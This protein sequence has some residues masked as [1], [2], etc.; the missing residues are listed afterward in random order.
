VRSEDFSEGARGFLNTASVGVPPRVAVEAMRDALG[1]W[2]AGRV[3][4]PEY[5]PW[6][7]RG[8]A[9][10]ARLH[11]ADAGRVAIG[12]QVS[13]FVGQVAAGLPAGARV[14]AYEDD[15]TSLLWPFLARSELDVR[16]VP[17]EAVAGAVEAG[18]DVVAFSAVQSADGRVAD[19]GAIEAAAREHGALTV[20][21]ATQASGWLPL[22]VERFDVVITA[23][24]K[25]L[26]CPRGTAFMALADGVLDRARPTSP[27]WYAAGDRRWE[28]IYGSS[29]ELAIDAR[30]LDLSPAW[31]DWVGTAVTLEYLEDVGVEAI[32]EHDVRLA[33]R[34]R[35]GL[36]LEAGDS[37]VVSL[38]DAAAGA[39]LSEAG[40]VVAQRAG[41]TRV[42]FHLYNDDE[43]VEAALAALRG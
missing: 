21:D 33:N 5:D 12:P 36:G 6:V 20:V 27:G 11:G 37:A 23:A 43:D 40:L 29:L 15:F 28:E 42:C 18:T 34:L 2:A 32:H 35:A 22:S 4:P 8:R 7:E 26:L 38:P 24:Y 41:S 10:F 19:L 14:V 16:L 3:Q 1:D 9:A 17:F 30:R 39:R 13:Y 25:W 31:L